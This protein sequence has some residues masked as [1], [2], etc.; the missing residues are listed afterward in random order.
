MDTMD[1]METIEQCGTFPRFDTPGICEACGQWCVCADL[2]EEL[3][4]ICWHCW[5]A[6]RDL[7]RPETC[8]K[9]GRPAVCFRTENG[10]RCAGC[11]MSDNLMEERRGDCERCGERHVLQQQA[12]GRWLCLRCR[13]VAGT[14]TDG[15]RGCGDGR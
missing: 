11:V 7:W 14:D 9:C 13:V 2:G 1:R 3:G 15:R 5:S 4:L 12:D 6:A 8:G 10:W